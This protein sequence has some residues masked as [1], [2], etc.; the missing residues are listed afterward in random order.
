[1]RVL[2]CGDRNWTDAQLIHDMLCDVAEGHLDRISCVIDGMARG[3]DTLGHAKAERLGLD[4]ERYRAQWDRYG[5]G[6][7]PKRNQQMLTEGRPDLVLAF[8]D[9]LDN[10]KGTRHMV[11]LAR[12][13]GVEV[14]VVQHGQ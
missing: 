8:H 3:A 7:G 11:G 5:R 12:K 2:V 13:A 4:T 1:M 14:R 9:D 6:A 10:S